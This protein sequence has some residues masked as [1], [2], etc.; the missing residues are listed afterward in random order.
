ME[1][2]ICKL[3][4]IP[5]RAEANDRSEMVS[6]LLFGE[7]F[8][9]IEANQ[10]WWYINSHH[11]DYLGWIDKKQA[12]IID[13]K[14]LE[15]CQS[16][17]AVYT[18][19]H[20]SSVKENDHHLKVLPLGARLPL[21][22]KG[23]CYINQK[24]YELNKTI[25]NDTSSVRERIKNTAMSL[26]HTPYLWGGRSRFGIDC[27]GLTQLCYRMGGISIYRDASQQARQGELL[28]FPEEAK[29]GDLAFFDNEEGNITHAGIILDH[30][31][32]I[33]ASGEVRIDML[34]NQGIFNRETGKHSHQLRLIRSFM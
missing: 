4:V 11:D 14:F 32:I 15:Q 24:K 6:Q 33:H 31:Q 23:N 28:S 22:N 21:Y 18:K 5:V 19:D 16:E 26:L 12:Q 1:Y 10:N 13:A 25:E 9:I 3:T 17:K 7:T 29:T 8:D 27:S 34:D 30:Q 20:I 2:G